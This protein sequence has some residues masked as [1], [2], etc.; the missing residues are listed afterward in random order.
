MH[1]PEPPYALLVLLFFHF[2][3]VCIVCWQLLQL[4]YEP[5]VTL[6]EESFPAI[7]CILTI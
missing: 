5:V 1:V 4:T 7:I 6:V 3:F 2:R